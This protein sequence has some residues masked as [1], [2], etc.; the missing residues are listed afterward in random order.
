M[1]GG[2]RFFERQEVK[3]ALAYLRLIANSEDDGALLRII[4]FPTR[5]IG[6]RTIE[7]IRDLAE[8]TGTSLWQAACSAPLSGRAVTAVTSFITLIE[9]LKNE[10]SGFSLPDLIEHSIESSGLIEH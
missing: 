3:H 8:Q 2:L 4:N 7:H 9:K 1:Y 5:G 6:N 10:T